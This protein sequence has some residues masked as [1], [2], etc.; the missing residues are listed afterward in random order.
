MIPHNVTWN[1]VNPKE[2]QWHLADG[3]DQVG[4][5]VSEKEC[6][7]MIEVSKN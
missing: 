1:H 4:T 3:R 7:Y 2:F 5:P 6:A